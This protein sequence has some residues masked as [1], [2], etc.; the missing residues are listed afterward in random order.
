MWRGRF[1]RGGT[2]AASRPGSEA[3]LLPSLT[4]IFTPTDGPAEFRAIFQPGHASA[5]VMDT[6]AC[7]VHKTR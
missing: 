1:A 4:H 7:R 5:E 3:R 2:P 6:T